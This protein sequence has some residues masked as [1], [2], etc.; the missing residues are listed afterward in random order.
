VRDTTTS[1]L[2]PQHSSERHDEFAIQAAWQ[3]QPQPHQAKT[4]LHSAMRRSGKQ[5][6]RAWWDAFDTGG[7]GGLRYDA[8]FER[9][10]PS[11]T[12]AAADFPKAQAALKAAAG[13]Q[14]P[15]QDAPEL[16]QAFDE[17]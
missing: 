12:V 5:D 7:S 8:L 13:K 6:A 9:G 14:A 17:L 3:D 4:E 16:K 11:E 1:A 2:K 15:V 10:L